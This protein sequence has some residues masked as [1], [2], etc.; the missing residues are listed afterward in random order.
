MGKL[1][2]CALLCA[3]G[4]MLCVQR[5][6]AARQELRLLREL[7]AA[8]ESI[9][10]LIRWQKLPLPRAIALQKDRP[11]CGDK[12]GQICNLLQSGN[13]LHSVWNKVFS[14]FN[15]ADMKEIVC[16]IEWSGDEEQLTGNLRYVAQQLRALAQEIAE[17]KAQREKLWIAL[18]TAAVG[19]VVIILL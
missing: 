9:E 12:F 5:I 16:H 4:A 3:G 19:V 17:G 10:M 18:S 14:H 6:T 11:L 2:G 13:A 15:S 1:L 7:A 8:L